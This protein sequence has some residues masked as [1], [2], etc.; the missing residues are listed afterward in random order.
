MKEIKSDRYSVIYDGSTQTVNFHGSFRRMGMAE[1]EPIE[2]L[3]QE[4][5][6]QEPE[7]ITWNMKDLQ[8]LN[9]AGFR[10]LS[11]LLISLRNNKKVK[12]KIQG[13]KEITWQDTSLKNFKR[14]MPN[15]ILE[16]Q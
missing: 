5:A 14:L 2:K 15:L 11:K 1:Y 4:I 10:M 6:A 8:L 16:W 3:L 9:S 7:L 13:C 12:I